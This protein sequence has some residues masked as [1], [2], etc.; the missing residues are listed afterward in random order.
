MTQANKEVALK[1]L[2]SLS[3]G[4]V[5]TLKSVVSED[6]VVTLPGTAKIAATRYYPEVIAA[7]AM[8]PQIAKGGIIPTVLNVTAEDDRVAVEWQ[9]SCELN[10]GQRYDNVYHFLLFIRDGK[11]Y[12]MKEYLDTK[13]ADEVIMPFL[14]KFTG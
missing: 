2:T 12:K 11:V 4:D 9:G 13:L 6:V 10:N 7:C 3:T 8:F 5:E 1:F 14:A